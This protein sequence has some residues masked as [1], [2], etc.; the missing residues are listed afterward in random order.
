M[1]IIDLKKEVCKANKMLPQYGLVILTWG[2]VSAF[3]IESKLMVI[4]PSGVAYEDLTPGNMVVV[5]LD[6]NV[7]D[8]ELKASSDTYTHLEIYKNFSNIK[9]IVH[10]MGYNLGT[11]GEKYTPFRNNPC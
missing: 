1:K 11:N 6:G 8:G 10:T 9:S 4:K 7:V 5:D 2:N 3:D